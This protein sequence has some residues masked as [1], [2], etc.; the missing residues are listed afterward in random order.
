MI[1]KKDDLETVY[2]GDEVEA[3][4]RVKCSDGLVVTANATGYITLARIFLQ[5]AKEEFSGGVACRLDDVTGLEKGSEDL[6]LERV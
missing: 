2:Y 4:I 3:R 5:L 1:L 6:L